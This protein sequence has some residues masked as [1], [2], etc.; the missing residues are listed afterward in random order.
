MECWYKQ[1]KPHEER[2]G[3]CRRGLLALEHGA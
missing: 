3:P 1:E 2:C